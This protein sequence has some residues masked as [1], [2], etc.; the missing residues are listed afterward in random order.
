MHDLAERGFIPGRT[1]TDLIAEAKAQGLNI[2][3]DVHSSHLIFNEEAVI[4]F[5]SLF[6]FMPPLRFESDRKALWEGLADGTIDA[7]ASDH[8]PNDTEEKNVEFKYGT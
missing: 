1:Y 7:I 8:R 2:T 4:G 6:K 3:A 5:D